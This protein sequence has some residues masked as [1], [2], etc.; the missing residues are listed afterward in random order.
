M[1]RW[2]I[3]G[4]TILLQSDGKSELEIGY[5]APYQPFRQRL[6]RW[7]TWVMPILGILLW[8]L[9]ADKSAAAIIIGASI[10]YFVVS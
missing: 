7:Q 5:E 9:L 8:V 2:T 6:L 10:I 1:N 3:K 4:A